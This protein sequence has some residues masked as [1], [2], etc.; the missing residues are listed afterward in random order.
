MLMTLN[1]LP[2]DIATHHCVTGWYNCFQ[3]QSCVAPYLTHTHFLIKVS[4]NV[5][6]SQVNFIDMF[7]V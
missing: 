2:S 7:K 1:Y 3:R 4:L 5:N 6:I